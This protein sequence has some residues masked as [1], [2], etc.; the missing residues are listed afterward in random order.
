[1]QQPKCN[2]PYQYTV[3]TE[4]RSKDKRALIELVRFIKKI[5]NEI[6]TTRVLQKYKTKSGDEKLAS[7]K[8][9]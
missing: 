7:S 8:P 6:F 3:T 9:E 5:E 4:M 1:M 2:R